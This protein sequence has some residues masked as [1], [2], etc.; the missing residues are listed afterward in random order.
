M[1]IT[2]LMPPMKNT[3]KVAGETIAPQEVEES[4]DQLGGVR[5]CAAVGVDRGGAAGEQMADDIMKAF[6]RSVLIRR[7][8]SDE[9]DEYGAALDQLSI[10]FVEA[11]KLQ[12]RELFEWLWSKCY[13]HHTKQNAI[14]WIEELST[15]QKKQQQLQTIQTIHT[16]NSSLLI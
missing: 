13:D 1:L 2:A 14:E 16:Y 4:V 8:A 3:I 11:W 9:E 10:A 7:D 6:A 15:F 12:N 5:F